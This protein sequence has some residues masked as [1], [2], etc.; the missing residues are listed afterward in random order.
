MKELPQL[1]PGNEWGAPIGPAE[2]VVGDIVH[3]TGDRHCAGYG[4]RVTKAARVNLH[5]ES[6][7]MN[8]QTVTLGPC[9]RTEFDYVKRGNVIHPV[10]T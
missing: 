9:R 3:R 8:G 7:Y 5:I 1:A 2:I 10:T 4:G 6:P